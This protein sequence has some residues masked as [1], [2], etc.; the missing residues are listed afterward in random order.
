MALEFYL[1][2]VILSAYAEQFGLDME[3]QNVA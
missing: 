1:D 2:Y 3:V